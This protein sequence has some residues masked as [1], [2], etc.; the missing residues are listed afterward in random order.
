MNTR[1]R[2]TPEMLD[3]L[4]ELMNI[5]V[6]RAARAIAELC[7]RE[8]GLRVL[9]VD[10]AELGSPI[11]LADLQDQL[12]L[13]ISQAFRGGLEGHALLLF[14]HRGA[15]R[16]AQLLLEKP[17]GDEAFDELEQSA[18]LELGNIV[19]GA[20]LGMLAMQMRATVSYDLPQLQL[21]G[22]GA[23]ADLLADV[24]PLADKFVLIM[25]ASLALRGETVYGYLVLLFPEPGL[26]KL[27]ACL[28]PIAGP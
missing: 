10:V 25:R 7:G 28:A 2:L 15:V 16:L 3:A 12:N 26:V 8:V 13:R 14:N 19:V 23:V 21:R 5:G 1:T 27:R 18:L 22:A 6:G 4:R 11:Y 9:E 17:A 24:A 20:A